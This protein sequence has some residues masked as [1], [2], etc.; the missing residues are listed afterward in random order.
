MLE[1]HKYRGGKEKI[2]KASKENDTLHIGDNN[3]INSWFLIPKQWCQHIQNAEWNTQNSEK[4][5]S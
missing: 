4:K 1:Q 5:R 3:K 2:L